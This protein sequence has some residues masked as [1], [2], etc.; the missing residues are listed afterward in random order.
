[1]DSARKTA[2]IAGWAFII[3]I[4]ASIPAQFYFY[5]PVL[6]HADYIVGAG[7]DTRVSIGAFL[8]VLTAIANIATAVVLFPVLKRQSEG[9]A[10]G[11]VAA[12]VAE[13]TIIAVGVISILSIVTLRQDLAGVAGTDAPSLLTAG[14]SLVAFR[15]ATFLIGPGI[16]AG[17]GN[18]LMLGYLMYRSGLVPRGMALLGLIGGP[19]VTAS[20]IAVLL[21]VWDQVSAPSLIATIPEFLWE[22][23][24]GIYLVVKGFRP[25][26]ILADSPTEPRPQY[27]DGELGIP[28]PRHAAAD[29]EPSAQ[30]TEQP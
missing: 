12:R 25:S 27:R 30:P 16:I 13:S 26:P 1:M 10:L 22:S 9:L 23:S 5:E 19:L 20:G 4:V 15:D 11:Y 21:G 7:T 24:L 29:L 18:G 2:R 28:V 6:A 3:T 14:R 17:L 8:E